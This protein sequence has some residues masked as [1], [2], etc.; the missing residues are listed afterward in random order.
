[1]SFLRE[2]W[3]E[4][5]KAAKLYSRPVGTQLGPAAQKQ[6]TRPNPWKKCPC[7]YRR[8]PVLCDTAE[9]GAQPCGFGLRCGCCTGPHRAPKAKGSA[10]GHGSG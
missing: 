6:P 7:C 10:D 5:Q 2:L 3:A 4:L 9:E 1:M 8:N